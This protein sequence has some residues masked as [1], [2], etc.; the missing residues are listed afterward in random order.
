[1]VNPK[2]IECRSFGILI[3]I[4][5][6]FFLENYFLVSI[7]LILT[8][9]VPLVFYIFTLFTKSIFT[10][11]SKYIS[12]IFIFVS[13]W[14]FI[15]PYCYLILFVKFIKKTKIKYNDDD[16]HKINLRDEYN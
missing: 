6:F 9:F 4:L 10:Q 13:Y 5:T 14:F 7:F 3:I 15:S 8:T 12:K 1:M 16:W 11:I 2:R